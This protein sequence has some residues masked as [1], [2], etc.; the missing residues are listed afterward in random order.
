MNRKRRR[1]IPWEIALG[2]PR[3]CVNWRPKV[4]SIEIDSGEIRLS[5]ADDYET[6]I[7]K[8]YCATQYCFIGV[9]RAMPEGI[10]D[11]GGTCRY[12]DGRLVTRE[13]PAELRTNSQH[14]EVIAGHPR[15][16]SSVA[17]C[18]VCHCHRIGIA[19]QSELQRWVL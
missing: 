2:L 4:S 17:T 6:L 9:E 13:E 1:F 5:N 18:S 7:P 15:F 8:A 19:R 14:V 16:E 10:A 3:I 12:F 11:H